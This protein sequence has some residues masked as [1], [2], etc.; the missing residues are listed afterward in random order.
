MP[1]S[2]IALVLASATAMAAVAELPYRLGYDNVFLVFFITLGPIKAIGDYFLA[3]QGLTRREVLTLGLKV[4]G[5]STIT[6]LVAG[7]AGSMMLHKWHISTSVMQLVAGI[8]FFV[9]AIRLVFAQYA[10][11]RNELAPV[12]PVKSST[13]HL[14]FP[15]TVTPYGLAAL[16][17]IMAL[18]QD[19]VR[20]TCLMGL[21][22]P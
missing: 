11:P 5:L 6:I 21:R 18:S 20:S 10:D 19:S 7:L 13:M 15:A 12:P 14:V 8:I 1:S 2:E 4:F 9:V 16:I 3:T 17:T 22:W